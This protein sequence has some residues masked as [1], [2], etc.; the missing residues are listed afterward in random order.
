MHQ[1]D[2]YEL[3]SDKCSA[4]IESRR[5]AGSVKAM[6]L[7]ANF[8]LEIARGTMPTRFCAIHYLISVSVRFWATCFACRSLC[9][10]AAFALALPRQIQH[11]GMHLEPL[12]SV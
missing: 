10:A 12:E 9:K 11:S 2:H 4:G 7:R 3:K 5:G 8:L 6:A 1:A